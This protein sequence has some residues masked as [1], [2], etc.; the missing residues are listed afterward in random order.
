MQQWTLAY[1]RESI[2]H[3][4]LG[5]FKVIQRDDAA[6]FQLELASTT[7][8]TT[9]GDA[10]W[11]MTVEALAEAAPSISQGI[12]DMTVKKCFFND[13]CLFPFSLPFPYNFISRVTQIDGQLNHW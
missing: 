4:L 9:T 10:I 7:T 5:D 3:S 8:T 12:C 11:C 6:R 13:S 1:L 2:A